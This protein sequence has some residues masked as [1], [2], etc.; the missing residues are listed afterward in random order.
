MSVTHS[1]ITAANRD[2][3]KAQD[4]EKRMEG[5]LERAEERVQFATLHHGTSQALHAQLLL[6]IHKKRKWPR[7]TCKECKE[8]FPCAPWRYA[9]GQLQGLGIR[10]PGLSEIVGEGVLSDSEHDAIDDAFGGST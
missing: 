8:A 5:K 2:R 3:Y 10:V 9:V 6:D 4:S 1:L 7:K